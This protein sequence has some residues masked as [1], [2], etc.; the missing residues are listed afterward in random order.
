MSSEA[1]LPPSFAMIMNLM[2]IPTTNMRAISNVRQSAVFP[3]QCFSISRSMTEGG[4]A[5]AYVEGFLMPDGMEIPIGHAWFQ[6]STGTHTDMT[7]VNPNDVYWG[8]VVPASEFKERMKD[9]A[10]VKAY[11]MHDMLPY[12]RAKSQITTGGKKRRSR[13]SST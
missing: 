11:E 8:I 4:I 7:H 9:P 1:K 6:D 12:H 13:K 3:Q 10:F 2:R 5:S